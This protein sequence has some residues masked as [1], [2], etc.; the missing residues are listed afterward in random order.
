[1]CLLRSRVGLGRRAIQ[2]LASVSSPHPLSNLRLIRYE[3][4]EPVNEAEERLRRLQLE[5]QEW[6]HRYWEAHNSSF[7]QR[8]AELLH[9]SDGHESKAPS[10]DELAVF[11]KRFLDEN[12][13]THMRYSL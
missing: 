7:L 2:S 12:R 11:Y 9:A 3:G 8:K 1:M 4:L 6:N 10:V 5:L 13:A